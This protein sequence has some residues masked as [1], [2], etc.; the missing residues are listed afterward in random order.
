[1][2]DDGIF[3][4]EPGSQVR[5]DYEGQFTKDGKPYYLRLL[6]VH[7]KVDAPGFTLNGVVRRGDTVELRL[8]QELEKPT[9]KNP[10]DLTYKGFDANRNCHVVT[11]TK[12]E[13]IGEDY[14]AIM[15]QTVP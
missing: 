9:E 15:F 14:Y 2:V 7:L 1:M 12:H 10:I 8:A 3:K 5:H 4:T 11:S 6:R 13:K